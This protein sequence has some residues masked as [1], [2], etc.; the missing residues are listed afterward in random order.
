MRLAL[1]ILAAALLAGCTTV[2]VYVIDSSV[3][4][5]AVIGQRTGEQHG[6]R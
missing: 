1:A 3:D 5:S 4:V 6:L 2:N